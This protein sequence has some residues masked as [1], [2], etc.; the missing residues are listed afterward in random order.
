MDKTKYR[1]E[2]AKLPKYRTKN[3]TIPQYRKSQCSPSYGGLILQFSQN[4]DI[5]V[6]SKDRHPRIVI[7]LL[8]VFFYSV[9]VRIT[10]KIRVRVGNRVRIKESVRL[11]IS[12]RADACIS[13]D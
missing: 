9:M 5:L 6:L 12:L 8:C 10:V 4:R 3:T 11:G 13:G 7:F 2:A 1:T